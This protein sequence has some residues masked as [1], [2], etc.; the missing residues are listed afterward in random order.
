MTHDDIVKQYELQ[1][2]LAELDTSPPEEEWMPKV[3][4]LFEGVSHA[5]FRYLDEKPGA[6]GYEVGGKE[7]HW[8]LRRTRNHRVYGPKLFDTLES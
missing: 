8:K 7:W 4:A 2:A 5:T 6:L 1:V 3:V